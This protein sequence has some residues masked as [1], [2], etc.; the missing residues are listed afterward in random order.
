MSEQ[1][2]ERAT[3]I[4]LFDEKHQPTLHFLNTFDQHFEQMVMIDGLPWK[5]LPDN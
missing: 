1:H 2:K 3:K 4:L 5:D